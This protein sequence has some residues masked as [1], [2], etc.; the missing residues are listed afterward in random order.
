METWHF[1][2]WVTCFSDGE[3]KPWP[4]KRLLGSPRDLQKPTTQIPPTLYKQNTNRHGSIHQRSVGGAA[5]VELALKKGDLVT[6][7]E[8]DVSVLL[9]KS[10]DGEGNGETGGGGRNRLG[11]WSLEAYL[12]V[13]L[14]PSEV[15]KLFMGVLLVAKL[16]SWTNC[17]MPTMQSFHVDEALMKLSWK[18]W[19]IWEVRWW[20]TKTWG[21]SCLPICFLPLLHLI[22]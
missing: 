15:L 1:C 5:A 6:V 16:G 20:N 14:Y 8:D 22:F 13:I 12:Y 19:E 21:T 4:F 10:T 18:Q 7:T 11:T 3:W 2:V 17:Y 9:L